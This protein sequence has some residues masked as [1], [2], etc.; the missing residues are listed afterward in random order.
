[1]NNFE[2]SA[3]P[4]DNLGVVQKL[5]PWLCVKNN[6]FEF[7][8]KKSCLLWRQCFFLST[9]R[10]L[11][12]GR[13]T[14]GSPKFLQPRACSCICPAIA[15]PALWRQQPGQHRSPQFVDN[16]AARLQ[17]RVLKI[18]NIHKQLCTASPLQTGQN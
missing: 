10:G 7:L 9:G 6:F 17:L 8:G 14:G 13:P 4:V 2:F 18:N 12:G 1:M 11:K 16:L 3:R 15:Q 5:S